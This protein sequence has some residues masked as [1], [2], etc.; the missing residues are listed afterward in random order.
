MKAEFQ[1]KEEKTRRSNE[2]LS[3]LISVL[4]VHVGVIV[5]YYERFRDNDARLI[6]GTS[7]FV[8]ICREDHTAHTLAANVTKMI[9][10][11]YDALERVEAHNTEAKG[12]GDE[13]GYES[14][15]LKANVFGDVVEVE[16]DGRTDNL[17]A[18]QAVKQRGHVPSRNVR[19][20]L[21]SNGRRRTRSFCL[22]G[23]DEV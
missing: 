14:F 20:A 23:D 18:Y 2:D 11:G 9:D 7:E 19:S 17:Y 4:S 6:M 8:A 1:E 16:S 3:K 5:Q 21:K 22:N 15:D 12:Y 10:Y 13:D